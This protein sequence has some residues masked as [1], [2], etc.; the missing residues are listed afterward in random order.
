MTRRLPEVWL[1]VGDRVGDNRQTETLAAA[2]GWPTQRKYACVKPDFAHSKPK[3]LATLEH[4]D[5][6]KSDPLAPPWPDLV[7][8]MGRRLSMVALWIAQRSGGRTRTVLLGK[9]SGRLD[10]FD[11]VVP[12]GENPL[13]R[14]PNVLPIRLPL[15]RVDEGALEEARVRWTPRLASLPRPLTALLVGGPTRPY[16]FDGRAGEALAA[17]AAEAAGAGTLF[18]TTSPRT[19]TAV[20]AALERGLPPGSRLHRFSPDAAENPYLGLLALAD[21]F[22]VTADSISMMVEVARLGRPLAI[23]PLEVEKPV[24]T[25][26]LSNWLASRLLSSTA[27]QSPPRAL[28]PLGLSLYHRGLIRHPR[29]F[30]A[31]HR[32]LVSQG[33]AVML[34]EPIPGRVQPAEDELPQV[35]RRI[36]DLVA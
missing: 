9:P 23:F 20:Q 3:V 10:D 13:P 27:S 7:V 21:R 31:I 2:L 33:V 8:T 34:G 18:A 26:R 17:G 6:G 36:R 29:D 30:G 12:S 5:E 32:H 19:P 22:V 1:L 35:V 15:T 14:C 25:A 11:L 24:L 4:V 16:R 28:E